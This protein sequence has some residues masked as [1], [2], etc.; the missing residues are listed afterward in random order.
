MA[1]LRC[2]MLT[3]YFT[4]LFHRGRNWSSKRLKD[5]SM[6]FSVSAL[7]KNVFV[8]TIKISALVLTESAT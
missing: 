6:V 8:L 4:T 5:L 3:V 2:T 7:F 1:G